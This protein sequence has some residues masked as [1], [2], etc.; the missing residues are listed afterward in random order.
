MSK[1]TGI[2][3]FV[4]LLGFLVA[5]PSA[6]QVT[7]WTN[8]GAGDWDEPTNWSNTPSTFATRSINNGGTAQKRS[9]GPN[10]PTVQIGETLTGSL[11]IL[12]PGT[13]ESDAGRVAAGANESHG[14]VL[15]AGPGARWTVSQNLILGNSGSAVLELR[16]GASLTT[17]GSFALGRNGGSRGELIAT[18]ASVLET[19]D[20][21]IAIGGTAA[22]SLLQS[23]RATSVGV[24]IGFWDEANGEVLV[25]DEGSEWELS[26][27][28]EIANSG[29][30]LVSVDRRA[31]LSAFSAVLG[32]RAFGNGTLTLQNGASAKFQEV[33]TVGVNGNGTLTVDG[34]SLDSPGTTMGWGNLAKGTATVRGPES[35][36]TVRGDL[37]LGTFGQATLAVLDGGQLTSENALMADWQ[38]A[39]ASTLVQ[40]PGSVWQT[41]NLVIG[42]AGTASLVV[43]DG[44]RVDASATVAVGRSHLGSASIEVAGPGAILDVAEEFLLGFANPTTLLIVDGG[45]LRAGQTS[46]HSEEAV[47]TATVS[48][49]GSLWATG[50]AFDIGNN[51]AAQLSILQGATVLSQ[52]VRAGTT[53]RGPSDILVSG[54]GS[55]WRVPGRFL[56]GFLGT[57]NLIVQNGARLELGTGGAAGTLELGDSHGASGIVNIGG[58]NAPGLLQ[59]GRIVGGEGIARLTLEHNSPSY[60]LTQDG[61]S[62]SQAVIIEG[63]TSVDHIGSGNTSLLGDHSYTGETGV[64]RG[65]LRVEG[66]IISPTTVSGSGTL[67]GSGTVNALVTVSG[68]VPWRRA[69]RWA[70]FRWPP[71][72]SAIRLG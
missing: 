60:A 27:P 28:M 38:E 7:E 25:A 15:I 54:L 69:L 56:L 24:S 22:F 48:G 61:T 32:L 64:S 50:S 29:T 26:G 19:G 72:R 16:D 47:A 36:W 63:S 67:S 13:L 42:R 46:M 39:N 57:G 66:S 18:G 45:W 59:V 37:M 70:C 3:T 53:S 11:H 68:A 31:R 33:L 5:L 43:R 4:V 6:A 12:A 44:G 71:C 30:A 21:D 14:E 17:P 65:T 34:S 55:A 41:G 23:S 52:N 8:P 51:G 2:S 9:I 1:Q 35:N 49:A 10:L 40:G 62:L 20:I 58:G